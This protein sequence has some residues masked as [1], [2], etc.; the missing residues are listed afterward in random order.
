M[1]LKHLR[2]TIGMDLD[3]FGN[4]WGH[5]ENFE[6]WSVTHA[7][8][9]ERTEASFIWPTLAKY[10]YPFV[11]IYTYTLIEEGSLWSQ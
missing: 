3:A 6:F 5:V 4:V 2:N 10:T 7:R 9:D 8:T 11:H 1:G